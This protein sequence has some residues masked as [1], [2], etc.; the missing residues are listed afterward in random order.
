MA[1]ARAVDD[2]NVQP[3]PI[4]EFLCRPVVLVDTYLRMPSGKFLLIAKAGQA[5]SETS[6]EK[7]STRN[8]E[9]L[10]VHIEDYQR[11]LTASIASATSVVGS[12]SKLKP[13]TQVTVIQDAMISVYREISDI[14]FSD[15]SYARAKL[16]NHALMSYVKEN[17]SLA[18]L[19]QK[20]GSAA[21]SDVGHGMMVSMVSVMIGMQHEWVKPA[22]LEKLSLGGFLHDVGRSKVPHEILNKQISTLSRDERLIYESHVE[23]GVQILSKSKS[24]PD[25][26]LLIVL[27]HHERSDG[28]GFPKKIKDIFISPLARVVSLANA[29]VE[30]IAEES[31]PLSPIEAMSIFEEFREARTHQFNRDAIKAL[32][33]SLDPKKLAA[34]ELKKKAAG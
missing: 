13:E 1:Q 2:S 8:I 27:E 14:G 23:A 34:A 32:G 21:T 33:K 6:L 9:S 16:V 7:F 15:Q 3:I 26:I 11:F 30:R 5:T 24:V 4:A 20:F 31:R 12:G 29:F 18:E 10:Y 19:I 17:A 25:D 28:S 22:T